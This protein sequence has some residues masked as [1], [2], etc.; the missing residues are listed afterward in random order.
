MKAGLAFYLLLLCAL[1]VFSQSVSDDSSRC[2]PRKPGPFP[3]FREG[4]PQ[5]DEYLYPRY[6]RYVKEWD[7]CFADGK[8]PASTVEQFPHPYPDGMK[9]EQRKVITLTARD[10]EPEPRES[11]WRVAEPG[12]EIGARPA[13]VTTWAEMQELKQQRWSD[14]TETD[15]RAKLVESGLE[16]LRLRLGA[17]SFHMLDDYV[18]E[19]YHAI[20]GQLVRQPLP[21]TAMYSRYLHTIA[22]MDK[23][24]A[25][26]GDDGQAAADARAE[27]QTACGLSD[28]EEEILQQVAED[29]QKEL[30][31]HR[32]GTMPSG[33]IGGMDRSARAAVDRPAE[34]GFRGGRSRVIDAHIEQLRS[35]LGQAGFEKVENRIR[36]IYEF[37][38][39][40]R[41]VPLDVPESQSKAGEPARTSR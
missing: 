8:W 29:L 10:W 11:T 35:G 21:E 18:H 28:K 33:T 2:L 5:T 12:A 6:F 19:L 23:F 1:P 20:P 3:V 24:A 36:V 16:K 27:E 30:S 38:G 26:G 40:P 17:T 4:R 7:E 22:M 25:N 9:E 37:D 39:P 14:A 41:V 32:P 13:E 31:E 15:E 34:P